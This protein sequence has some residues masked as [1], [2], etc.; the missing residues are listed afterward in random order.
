MLTIPQSLMPGVEEVRG[1]CLGIPFAS[2]P[3]CTEQSLAEILRVQEVLKR[4]PQID[5]LTEHVFHAGMYTRTIRLGAGVIVTGALVKVPTILIING[6]VDVFI[7]DEWAEVC[8]YGVLPASAGRKQV[9][10]TRSTVEM[11]M[12]FPTRAKTVEDVEAEFTAEAKDLLSRRN[13]KQ[14]VLVITGE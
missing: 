9:F 6:H 8:G 11:T 12:V 13:S 2:L 5:L 14:N 7:G 10:I 1:G 4:V 3:A